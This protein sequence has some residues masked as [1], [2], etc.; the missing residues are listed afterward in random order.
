MPAPPVRVV[1]L[2]SDTLTQPTPEMRRA[3]GE[4]DVGDDVFGEDPT[5]NRLEAEAARRL[6]MEAA[7]FLP[8]GTMA[9]QAAIFAHTRRQGE[10]LVE[11]EA[12]IVVYEC[13]AASMFSGV[14]LRSLP[15]RRGVFTPD[16]VQDALQEGN[17]HQAP[18]TLVCIENTHNRASGA[19]WTRAQTRAVAEVAHGADVP[20]H[21]DGARLFNSAVA[22]DVEVASLVRDVDSAMFSLSKGLS[23]P[24]GSLLCGSREFID[25]ARFARKALGGGMRQAGVLAAAGL[26]ALRTMGGRLAEDHANARR[27]AAAIAVLPGI[28]VDVDAVQSN[29]VVF[30]VSGTAMGA[31]A[32][33]DGL[34]ERGVKCLEEDARRLRFVTHRHVTRE[35]VDYAAKQLAAL[36][37]APAAPGSKRRKA[38]A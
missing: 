10:V 7:V 17:L 29:I 14:T 23:A 33:R 15:G 11:A 36:V 19:V 2:R 37:G 24:V 3:M 22:Q 16:Q 30:D 9:N 35:D 6:G 18:T 32:L 13:G 4:A 8:S 25:R 38:A 12:H 34:A 21:V 26:V 31:P 27:L 28:R 1:D 20:V 5:V